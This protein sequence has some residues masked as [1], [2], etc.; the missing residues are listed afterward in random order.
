[1]LNN[2]NS[3]ADRVAEIRRRIAAA[4]ARAGREA[5]AVQ[6]VAVTKKVPP[7]LIQL[8]MACGLQ[9]CG[10][11]RVQELLAKMPLFPS[12][13]WHLIGSLQTNKVRQVVGQV[14][15]IHSLDR[16]EL[17]R[18]LHKEGMARQR[19]IPVLVQVNISGE[20]SKRGFPPADVVPF[21]RGIEGSTIRVEG[22]MTM[23]PLVDDPEQARPLFRELRVLAEGIAG[24]A[25]FNSTMRHLSMGMTGDF[26][27]AVEEGAT[28]VR[29]GTGI[30]GERPV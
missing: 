22:L 9:I 5:A 18:A 14:E 10:E 12:I 26:E 17:A 27:V 7:E 6:V 13:R 19:E 25:L 30:F 20:L 21:L 28:L 15:L 3:L 24:M 29:I 4:A 23:A 2:S 1:M 11:N 16:L 8:A